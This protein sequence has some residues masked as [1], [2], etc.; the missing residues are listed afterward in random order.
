MLVYKGIY[1]LQMVAFGLIDTEFLPPA[2][3]L[4]NAHLLIHRTRC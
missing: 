3:I 4:E 2:L 1:N